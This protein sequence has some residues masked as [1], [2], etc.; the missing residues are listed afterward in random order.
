MVIIY[1]II[2]VIASNQQTNQDKILYLSLA[3]HQTIDAPSQNPRIRIPIN[4]AIPTS[5]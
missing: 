2:S 1:R 3:F 5:P 4:H